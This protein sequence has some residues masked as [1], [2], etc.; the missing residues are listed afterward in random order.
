MY[1][2]IVNDI[3]NVDEAKENPFQAMLTTKKSKWLMWGIQ[4]SARNTFIF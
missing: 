1:A 3:V 2:Y 4:V